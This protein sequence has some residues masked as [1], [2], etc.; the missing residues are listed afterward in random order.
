MTASTFESIESSFCWDQHAQL[1]VGHR[2]VTF[3][4]C[5]LVNGAFV[6][7]KVPKESSSLQCLQSIQIAS[8]EKNS[9]RKLYIHRDLEN[10]KAINHKNIVKLIDYEVIKT[11]KVPPDTM[12]RYVR[13]YEYC[14][15][16][17]LADLLNSPEYRY[18]LTDQ[19][20]L[21]LLKDISNGLKFIHE[22]NLVRFIS[23]HIV[24]I[25]V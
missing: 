24:F 1:S 13:F 21:S 20:F 25:L 23:T 6:V 7:A 2:S 19:I 16:G 15:G 10:L 11:N 8:T 9:A 3:K 12:R 18:G 17:T 22:N 4:A 14:N 5:H